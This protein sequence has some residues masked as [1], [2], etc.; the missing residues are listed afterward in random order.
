MD[1]SNRSKISVWDIISVFIKW[2]RLL[3]LNFFAAA[4][5]TFIIASFLPK[6]YTSSAS[7]FPPAQESTGLGFASLLG[8]GLG[9][10]LSSSGMSLPAFATLSDIHAAI[11]LSRQV[12]ERV[13]EENNLMEI[14]GTE[15][16]EVAFKALASHRFV[17]VEPTGI[18]VVDVEDK[19][20]EFAAQLV[21]SFI[22]GLNWIN[23]N[24]RTSQASATREFI[25]ERLDQTKVELE[26]AE[27][28]YRN[29][30]LKHKAISL[31]HQ[32]RGMIDN[33]AKLK[34]E[35]V[36]AEIELGVLKRSLLPTH[37]NVKQQEAKI[38][39]IEKQIRLLE[40][41]DSGKS[42]GGRVDIPIFD[43][44]S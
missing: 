23:L 39:E 17:R 27:I 22:D 14:Y 15:S 29:F 37:T 44:I 41:G 16:L 4:I 34:G 3:I 20:P 26:E 11:L 25:E 38:E 5:L 21:N 9:S 18:I 33:L 12:S 7:I 1:Q 28:A 36:L 32:L 8:G 40:V 2:R 43:K 19:D 10:M 30:Q 24:I 31:E 35:L 6:W 13:I 42:D